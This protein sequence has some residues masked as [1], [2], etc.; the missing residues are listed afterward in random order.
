MQE[1]LRS[2]ATE[3]FPTAILRDF[4]FCTDLKTDKWKDAKNAI[5]RKENSRTR[6][7]EVRGFEIL[8][9]VLDVLDK[10]FGGLFFCVYVCMYVRHVQKIAKLFFS[11][12]ST[13]FPFELNIFK[14][15]VN[16]SGPKTLREMNSR[17]MNACVNPTHCVYALTNKREIYSNYRCLC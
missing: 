15:N 14:K 7:R 3:N 13:Q 8:K 4:Q 11:V 6:S 5:D 9:K 2:G 12:R 16:I 17:N 10:I 1:R